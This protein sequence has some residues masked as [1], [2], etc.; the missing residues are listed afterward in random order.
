MDTDINDS[1]TSGNQGC[2]R[3]GCGRVKMDMGGWCRPPSPTAST[4]GAAAHGDGSGD[5]DMIS[6]GYVRFRF[7]SGSICCSKKEE[8][9]FVVLR[10]VVN[11]ICWCVFIVEEDVVAD[12]SLRD[13]RTLCC[14]DIFL[15]QKRKI[16]GMKHKLFKHYIQFKS[17]SLFVWLIENGDEG[18]V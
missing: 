5:D 1:C 13:L 4:A 11:S 12:F 2:L 18:G 9:E 17:G 16:F 6:A 14:C 15:A 3:G 10:W 7:D 8:V